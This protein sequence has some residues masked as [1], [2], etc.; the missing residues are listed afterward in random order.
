VT[1]PGVPDVSNT[2]VAALLADPGAA[3]TQLLVTGQYPALAWAAYICAGLAVGRSR[4]YRRSPV[5]GVMLLGLGLAGAA[6]AASWFLLD[7]AGGRAVLEQA[8][9]SSMTLQEYSEL[10]TVGVDGTLP[11]TSPWWLAVNAPHTG[12]PFDLI[13]TIG[14]ALLVLGGMILLGRAASGL[15]RPLAAAGSMVLTLY[16]AHLLLLVAPF[17]P[18]DPM[19]AFAAHVVV[20]GGFALVWRHFFARGPVEHVV[21]ALASRAGRTVA[22]PRPGTAPEHSDARG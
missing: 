20:L 18:E 5:A 8:A 16:A 4:L 10:L 19:T 12:T 2:T 17:M 6:S 11:A 1:V 14:V 22:G 13:F 15:L 3:A 7:R 9:L 21:R